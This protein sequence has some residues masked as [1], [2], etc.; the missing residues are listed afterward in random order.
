MRMCIPGEAYPNSVGRLTVM[1]RHIFILGKD[2]QSRWNGDACDSPR[3]YMLTRNA[4][5]FTG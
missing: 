2:V 3:M 5:S 4:H 1:M